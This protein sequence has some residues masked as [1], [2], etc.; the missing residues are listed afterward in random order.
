MKNIIQNKYCLLLFPIIFI[1][2][3]HFIKELK[4]NIIYISIS[5]FFSILILFYIFPILINILHTTPVY[6]EDIELMQNNID[7]LDNTSNSTINSIVIIDSRKLQKIFCII[8]GITG[9]LFIVIIV[10]YTYKGFHNSNLKMIEIIGIIGG[11][12][13]IYF[14]FQTYLGKGVL[15][16][17]FY[18]KRNRYQLEEGIEMIQLK[19]SHSQ[20]DYVDLSSNI[21]F[22]CSNKNNKYDINNIWLAKKNPQ[23]KDYLPTSSSHTSLNSLNLALSPLSNNVSYQINDK[24]KLCTC[25]YC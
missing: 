25:P 17:L 16:I 11:L 9:A 20:V 8:N 13:S 22:I 6:Y 2:L 12:I 21:S 1:T 7:V 19:H 15:S 4:N 10:N 14:K 3:E 23:L 18:I 24:N 5:A